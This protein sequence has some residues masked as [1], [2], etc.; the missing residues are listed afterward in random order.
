MAPRVHYVVNDTGTVI[1]ISSPHHASEVDHVKLLAS[2][3]KRASRV[4]SIVQSVINHLTTRL[5]TLVTEM[6]YIHRLL[7]IMA[8]QRVLNAT[9]A[10]NK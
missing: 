4:L 8:R 1:E 9:A 10:E 6:D 3:V 5:D 2:S 7:I